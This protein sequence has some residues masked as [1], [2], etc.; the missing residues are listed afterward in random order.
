MPML[1]SI[2]DVETYVR[3]SLIMPELFLVLSFTV[4]SFIVNAI[5]LTFYFSEVLS[6]ADSRQKASKDGFMMAFVGSVVG[7]IF[8]LALNLLPVVLPVLDA[9]LGL[10]FLTWVLLM[11]YRFDEG[12][13]EALMQAIIG[14]ILYVVI[15]VLINGFLQMWASM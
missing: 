10:V 1:N 4:I 5:F 12:W 6:S 7:A 15:L 8:S 14:I 3:V 11:H 9:A 2:A 13:L